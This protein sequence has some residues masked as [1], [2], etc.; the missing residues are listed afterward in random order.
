M[1]KIRWKGTK[2][3]VTGADGFIGSH[4]AKALIDKGSEV[5]TVVRDIKKKSNIDI[6]GLKEKISIVHGDL[7]DYS[8]CES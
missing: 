5:V 1:D 6:L 3:L 4:V 8:D 2:V 7:I